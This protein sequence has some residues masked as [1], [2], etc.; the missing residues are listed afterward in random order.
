MVSR[1]WKPV[2]YQSALFTL[3]MFCFRCSTK[4]ACGSFLFTW[5]SIWFYE[6]KFGHAAGPF[7]YFGLVLCLLCL[8]PSSI[9]GFIYVVCLKPSG[10]GKDKAVYDYEPSL[11][12]GLPH[13]KHGRWHRKMVKYQN[14]PLTD[15]TQVIFS[16]F[17]CHQFT[18]ALHFRFLTFV[19]V[20]K[21]KYRWMNCWHPGFLELRIFSLKP[22]TI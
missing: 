16:L 14:S 20:T 9:L 8:D 6:Q 21:N 18:A 11:F 12:K 15:L 7:R 10:K 3:T 13:S 17:L 5:K 19:T 4:Y 22:K 1:N 2:C